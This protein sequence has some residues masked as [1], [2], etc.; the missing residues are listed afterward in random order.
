MLDRT[1]GFDPNDLDRLSVDRSAIQSAT[2]PPHPGDGPIVR[3]EEILDR[4]VVLL[5]GRVVRSN[6]GDEP[7]DP[8]L[9]ASSDAGQ[10][11]DQ[12][13]LG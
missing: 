10:G 9:R 11:V 4:G 8:V 6:G 13:G 1:T 3:A 2:T 12:G 7:V 5:V